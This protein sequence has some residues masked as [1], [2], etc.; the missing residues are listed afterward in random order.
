MDDVEDQ[1]NADAPVVLPPQPIV[2]ERRMSLGSIVRTVK[3]N[4]WLLAGS[5][6]TAAT[7]AHLAGSGLPEDAPHRTLAAGAAVFAGRAGW[8][9]VRALWR[10]FGP[11][12]IYFGVRFRHP[13]R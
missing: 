3:L 8:S 9:S 1:V 4:V 10:Y 12:E 2:D 5:V 7:C 13:R 6:M 11:E